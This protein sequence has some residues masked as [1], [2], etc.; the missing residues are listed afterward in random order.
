MATDIV[1]DIDPFAWSKSATWKWGVTARMPSGS[2]K[3]WASGGVKV[4]QARTPSGFLCFKVKFVNG[5]H[6]NAETLAQAQEYA[7]RH[8]TEHSA[9]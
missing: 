4:A 7:E 2:P 1:R 8:A 5:R 6:F 9:I 3:A